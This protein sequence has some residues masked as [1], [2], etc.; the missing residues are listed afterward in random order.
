MKERIVRTRSRTFR[1]YIISY[2]GVVL[3]ALALLSI[4]DA[5]QIAVRMREEGFRVTQSKLYTIVADLE[6]QF[7]SMRI[8]AVEIASM[9]E[10]APY[11]FT[12]NKYREIELLDRLKRYRSG[13]SVSEYF[14]LKFP[15]IENV[16]TAEGTTMPLALYLESHLKTKDGGAALSFINELGRDSGQSFSLYK[17]EG[18]PAL[19]CYPLERYAIA[20]KKEGAL[21]FE[22]TEKGLRARMEKVAG[23]LE[24]SMALYYNG[25]LIYGDELAGTALK[26]ES[27]DGSIKVLLWPDTEKYFSWSNVLSA[28]EWL[29]FLVIA[30]ILL[31]IAVLAAWRSYRPIRNIARKYSSISD[32]DSSWELEVID[33]LI[34][35]L[36]RR[37]ERN[38]MLLQQY[39]AFREQTIRLVAEGGYSE[40]IRDRL[41]MLNLHLDMTI[42]CR[43]TCSLY[44]QDKTAEH[45]QQLCRDVEELSDDGVWLY[46]YWNE[47]GGLNILAALN[48][49][50]QAEEAMEAVQALLE[51]CGISAE[52]TR[53]AVCRD[54]TQLKYTTVWNDELDDGRSAGLNGEQSGDSCTAVL[55]EAHSSA[56]AYRDRGKESGRK[57]IT[58]MQAI[59]YIEKNCTR[60]DLSLDMVAQEFHITSAYL[61]RLIKQ[62]TGVNYKDYLTGLRM[63]AAKEM[64]KDKNASVSDVCQRTGYT[65]VSHFIK[66]F[67]KAEG[68]TPAKYRNEYVEN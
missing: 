26:R 23:E 2:V 58:V 55:E 61:C 13:G 46:P 9:E 6:S 68:V 51:A 8:T 65:N 60:Y 59:E 1:S 4:M 35:T 42:F 53:T 20:G 16:F 41:P 3:T 12:E 36:L 40:W 45:S 18:A 11:Y 62:Q 38:S 15:E 7:A 19:F 33:L 64:L 67:Q 54:L 34:D 17:S 48:E 44:L 37:D 14:F 5:R 31:G 29:V 43:I 25:I 10:F 66:I 56:Q 30:F 22:V 32:S 63:A 57:N 49:E 39:Q 50:Y 28:R 47:N 52:V 27:D 21:C 24:G